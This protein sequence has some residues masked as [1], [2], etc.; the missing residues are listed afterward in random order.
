[1]LGP[2]KLLGHTSQLS[3][4][5]D[6]GV[7]SVTEPDGKSELVYRG[8]LSIPVGVRAQGWTHIG[9][10]D[11]WHGYIV[12]AY[13]A[14]APTDKKMFRVTTPRGHAYEFVH[15][16]TP[17]EALNNSFAAISPD[18]HWLVSGEW[19][20]MHRLL[21]FADPIGRVSGPH[22]SGGTLPLAF[23]IVLEHPVRDVQGCVFF[24]AVQL[25]CSTNDPRT[26]LWPTPDQLLEVNLASALDGGT[27]G[28]QVES[29]GELPLA[30]RCA[31][32]SEVEGID[33]QKTTGILRVEV[34]P[35]GICGLSTSVYEYRR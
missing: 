20:E 1:M 17:G 5:A 32:A 22:P 12:D 19:G 34:V 11:S 25:L 14:A 8:E 21:V 4:F 3:I 28:A 7:T 33:Y 30:S 26:D 13:Q 15:T 35:P 9:D 16:L 18:G 2:W 31:G 24:T 23:T 10:P 27:V 29:L 6:E